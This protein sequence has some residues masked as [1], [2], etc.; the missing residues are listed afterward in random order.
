MMRFPVEQNAPEFK[1]M[2]KDVEKLL[3][4]NPTGKYGQ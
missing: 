1:K 4:W 2:L 3:K